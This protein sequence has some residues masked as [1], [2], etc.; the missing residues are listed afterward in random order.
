MEEVD[1]LACIS[2]VIMLILIFPFRYDILSIPI[3]IDSL[4][5]VRF[6]IGFERDSL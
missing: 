5:R 2:N 1:T 3:P 4:L 6:V